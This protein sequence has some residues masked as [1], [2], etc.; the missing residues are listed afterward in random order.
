MF[1]VKIYKFQLK[2]KTN[3]ESKIN[4]TYL[5]SMSHIQNWNESYRPQLKSTTPCLWD[6]FI[7]GLVWASPH[8]FAFCKRFLVGFRSVRYKNYLDLDF[9]AMREFLVYQKGS[10][11]SKLAKGLKELLA[12][13]DYIWVIFHFLPCVSLTI[14]PFVRYTS[15]GWGACV[16]YKLS[17]VSILEQCETFWC[18]GATVFV[19]VKLTSRRHNKP[20]SYI[21]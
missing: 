8:S 6:I 2:I 15:L 12:P 1:G 11:P 5:E 7:R 13:H 19:K 9:K 3:S 21:L 17:L 14:F 16:V 4:S 20:S 18:V 10:P